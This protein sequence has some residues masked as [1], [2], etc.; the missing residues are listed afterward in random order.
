MFGTSRTSFLP[1]GRDAA[2]RTSRRVPSTIEEG[3]V[4]VAITGANA[5]IGLRA[6]ARFARDGHEVLALCRSRERAETALAGLGSERERIRIETLDLASSVSIRAASE[7][8]AA[9]GPLDALVHNAAIFDQGIRRPRLTE[10]GHELF[11]A[12]NHLGPVELTARLSTALRDSG[13]PRVMFVASKGLLA[14][15]RLRIRF[16]APDGAGWFTP[17]RAY[18]HA[19]LAQVMTAITLAETAGDRLAVS[20][21]RV[22]A[23]RLDA[24]RLAAQ[25]AVLRALYAPKN[26]RAAAPES[27]AEVYA[28]L[29]TESS[30]RGPDE[31]Y[32]DERRQA[33]AAPA[34]ARDPRARERLWR[35]TQDSIGHPEWAW[36]V[37]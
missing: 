23:V 31:V 24:D 37:P 35:L 16:D 25:P 30:R 8:I 3:I 18:Y 1:I 15:P 26:R 36:P 29:V 21:L 9:A 22:P 4:R 17:T 11:W 13:A 20:C 19:K 7:R 12:T 27:I 6:A 5:G 34:G 32:V 10:D 14:M 2:V 33:V 28:A